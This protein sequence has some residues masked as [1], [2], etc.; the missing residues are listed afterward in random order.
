MSKDMKFD[1]THSLKESPP[2][3]PKYVRFIKRIVVNRKK[4]DWSSI[5]QPKAGIYDVEN[6]ASIRISYQEHGLLYNEEVQ[7]ATPSTT[8]SKEFEGISGFQ[9][10][11]A[12]SVLG[13]EYVIVDIVEYNSPLDR[14]IHSYQSNHIFA[15]RIG[16]TKVDIEYGVGEAIKAGELDSADEK[17]IKSFIS[18]TAADFSEGE[19]KAI[20][21]KVQK[22]LGIHAH[23]KRLDSSLANAL[24]AKL[25]LQYGGVKNKNAAGI[26]YAK[27]NGDSKTLYF[28]SLKS[29]VKFGW[30]EVIIYGF[31]PDPTHSTLA[32]LRNEWME[33]FNE[34]TE[35][36][37]SISA[38]TCDKDIGTVRDYGRCPFVFGGFLPQDVTPI[39][40]DKVPKEI[41]L[42]DVKG[43]AMSSPKLKVVSA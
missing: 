15:P 14:R 40:A 12:Q 32:G 4:I 6:V 8:S 5:Y 10:N 9:R 23:L 29:S 43:R 42:V 33:K 7:V 26:A 20:F 39:G 37:Y 28:D 31:I 11:E 34:L 17:A 3:Y 22:G 2:K 41:G 24:C 27:G 16:N 18:L 30:S 19:R 1:V 35:F 38:K 21:K 36:H 25:G 13:W